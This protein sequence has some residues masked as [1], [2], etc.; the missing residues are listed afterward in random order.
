MVL[1]EILLAL[2]ITTRIKKSSSFPVL[3]QYLV[4]TRDFD[5]IFRSY[6]S[7]LEGHSLIDP[8]HPKDHGI[9]QLERIKT[10]NMLC[11]VLG[12]DGGKVL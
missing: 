4:K 9:K 6:V 8:I 12:L 10:L 1:P 3:K 11:D 7:A 5:G 2:M